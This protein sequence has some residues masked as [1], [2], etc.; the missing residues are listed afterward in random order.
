MRHT[1]LRLLLAVSPL[2][3]VAL[4]LSARADTIENYNITFTS[5]N[6]YTQVGTGTITVN[7][8]GVGDYTVTGFSYSFYPGD[9]TNATTMSYD[10]AGLTNASAETGFVSFLPG[11]YGFS[12][13]APADPLYTYY[14]DG[15][16]WG[17]ETINIEDGGFYSITENVSATP[18]PGSLALLGTGIV[19]AAGLARRR[20]VRA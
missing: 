1:L 18:E 5:F 13:Y 17:F 12:F 2:A 16:G 8:D 20:L 11:E 14:G 19:A 10:S 15:T 4:P 3:L 7:D 6:S 9:P